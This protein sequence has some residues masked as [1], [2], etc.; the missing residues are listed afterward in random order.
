[1]QFYIYFVHECAAG[2][3]H[4]LL[5]CV[6]FVHWSTIWIWCGMVWYMDMGYHSNVWGWENFKMK[7]VLQRLYLFNQ[8]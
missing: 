8:K 5:Q 2:L 7:D 6:E 1:M 4:F 3:K